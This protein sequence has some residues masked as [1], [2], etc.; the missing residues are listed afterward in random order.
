[1]LRTILIDDESHSLESLEFGLRKHCPEIDIIA[2]SKGAQMGVDAIRSHKPDLVFLDIDMPV[3][4]G[5]ELLE[6]VREIPFDVIFAT[7][8]DEYAVRAIKVSAMDYL[9]KPIAPDDLKSAVQKVIDKRTQEDPLA[10]LDVLLTNFR[11]SSDGFQ[12]LAIPTLNGLDF[13]NIGDI[14]Y[15]IA[16]GSYTEVHTVEGE[17]YT[18]SKT[19]KETSELLQ[20]PE[21]FRTH[22]SYLINLNYIKKYIKGS[23]G[24][25]IM[26]NGK[27]IPVARARKDD[28]M[29]VIFKR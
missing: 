23:G 9:L 18:I 21:F 28:L 6:E 13:I 8:Y 22:Q 4:N 16:D 20:N 19:M 29:Q 27:S 15:C 7:A 26:L 1:M 24:Q 11:N 14:I 3:M 12:K 2:K 5:F 25:L 10:K 17:C